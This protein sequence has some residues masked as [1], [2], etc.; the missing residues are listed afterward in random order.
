MRIPIDTDSVMRTIQRH[1]EHQ[2]QVVASSS[3]RIATGSRLVGAVD[4]AAGVAIAERVRA[5]FEGLRQAARNTQEG[6]NF[7]QIAEGTLSQTTDLV[8]RMR[9][10]AVQSAN[11]TYT[12]DQRTLLQR[13]VV[14]TL[15]ELDAMVRRSHANDINL[16][17]GSRSSLRVQAGPAATDALELALGSN[18]SAALGL[19]EL[20]VATQADSVSALDRLDEAI[21][22]LNEH[23]AEMASARARM[24]RM[25][26][27]L[28]A[29]EDA[30]RATQAR[31]NDADLG[32]ETVRM[33]RAQIASDAGAAMMVHGRQATQ[34]VLNLLL[35]Q[36]PSGSGAA[37]GAVGSSAG[38]PA[39]AGAS[40]PKSG[41]V[42]T[43][44]PGVVAPGGVAVEAPRPGGVPGVARSLEPIAVSAGG[45]GG[46]GGSASGTDT[47]GRWG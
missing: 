26:T 36:E 19:T 39:G 2:Q 42:P 47:A 9:V 29:T 11:G 27:S 40:T 13:A 32:A 28:G 8:Q 17:D 1:W 43:S 41:A 18:D 46:T 37:A 25:I 7:V 30:T 23:R 20:S 16:V 44:P 6:V 4:D 24:E 12:D 22:V 45:S 21:D 38:A 3:A 14:L 15:D 35:P 33:L 10:I 5:Q 34:L 31:I